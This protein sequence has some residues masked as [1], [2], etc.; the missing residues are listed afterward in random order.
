MSRQYSEWSRGL[1]TV[2]E[3]DMILR[4]TLLEAIVGDHC[5]IENMKEQG[6][7]EEM[8]LIETTFKASDNSLSFLFVPFRNCGNFDFFV[9]PLQL[10]FVKISTSTFI[11]IASQFLGFQFV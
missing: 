3:L 9:L 11:F 10:F 4:W 5:R 7:H 6:K 8:S 1:R 2:Q